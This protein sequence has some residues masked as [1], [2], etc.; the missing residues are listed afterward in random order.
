MLFFIPISLIMFRHNHITEFADDV[1]F[2]EG[3]LSP[4]KNHS[5]VRTTIKKNSETV[6][7]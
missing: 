1:Y 5:R 6:I 3:I 7:A 4:D 2:V